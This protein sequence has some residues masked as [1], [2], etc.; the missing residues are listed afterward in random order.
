MARFPAARPG[1]KT[2]KFFVSPGA[3]I[4]DPKGSG[5]QL[6]EGDEIELTKDQ[7]EFLMK[8]RVIDVELPDFGD[9]DEPTTTEAKSTD[10][11]TS[12]EGAGDQAEGG[13]DAPAGADAGQDDVPAER[14]TSTKS[15]R[16]L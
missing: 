6:V 5:K 14:K 7:A 12:K 11:D 2:K 16:K 13:G 1:Q 3:R 8:L 15:G 4:G 9:D 10:G